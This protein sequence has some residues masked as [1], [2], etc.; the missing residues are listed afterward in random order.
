MKMN[1]LKRLM[2]SCLVAFLAACGGGGGSPGGSGLTSGSSAGTGISTGSGESTATVSISVADFQLGFNK[3]SLNNSGSDDVIVFVAAKDTNGNVVKGATASIAVDGD[4]FYS[5]ASNVTDDEGRVSGKI[6]SPFNKTD[7][8][9]NVTA[10]MGN[11]AK[12]A[13]IAVVGSKVS[14]TSIPGAPNAG[15]SVTY[16]VSV[17]DSGSVGIPNV[18]LSI[19]GTTGAMGIRKTDLNGNATID[20]IAPAA[21]GTFT[22]IV[23][24]SGVTLTQAITVVGGNSGVTVPDAATLTNASLNSNVAQ[25]RPNLSSSTANRAVLTF[26]M[27][28]NANQAVPNI[29][30]RFSIIA[31]G[32]GAGE[33]MSTGNSIVYTDSTGTA[34]SDYV[35][36][37]RSSPT[38]GVQVRACYAMTDAALANNACPNERI[39][40]LTVAGTALNLSIFSNNVAEGIGAGNIIY[41]KLYTIQ[42]ADAAGAP[43]PGA[44]VSAAVDIT[45]YGKGVFGARYTT[46]SSPPIITDNEA[47][48]RLNTYTVDANDTKAVIDTPGAYVVYNT[49]NAQT[50]TLSLKVWCANEDKNRNGVLDANEDTDS[51][52]ILDPRVSDVV[53]LPVTNN[54]TDSSGNVS[55]NVQWGQNVATWVAF[56]LKATTNVGGSEGTNSSSFVTNFIAGDEINGSFL[57]PPYGRGRCNQID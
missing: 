30:V 8:I 2:V 45:H 49:A 17:L 20:A 9:I 48:F 4:A 50:Q 47:N 52:G 19:S 7:R 33:S 12:K 3:N 46:G 31:P 16:K 55:F 37:Q 6:T 42:V 18:D 43:V 54:V 5:S 56:T 1:I 32:L 41:K 35:S 23:T 39:A 51:D 34:R 36:G 22:V 29:R 11:L 26:R 28:D 25:V 44:V 21:G 15:E 53:V 24:G 57:T 14:V 10:R 27:V 13:T 38:N 40:S